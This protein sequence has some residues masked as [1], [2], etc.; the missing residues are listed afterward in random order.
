M[1]RSLKTYILPQMGAPWTPKSSVF[2]RLKIS[3]VEFAVCCRELNLAL[4]GPLGP[5]GPL[6]PQPRGVDGVG[7]GT[8]V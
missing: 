6:G 2:K 3:P 7:G 5:S 4:Y 8:E 1:E